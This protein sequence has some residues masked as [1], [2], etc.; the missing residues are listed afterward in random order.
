[1]N[2]VQ[3]TKRLVQKQDRRLKDIN[4]FCRWIIGNEASDRKGKSG[5]PKEKLQA[6][7]FSLSSAYDRSDIAKMLQDSGSVLSL[8][9][10]DVSGESVGAIWE[11]ESEPNVPFRRISS[12]LEIGRPSKDSEGYFQSPFRTLPI[13]FGG[14]GESISILK[15]LS[16]CDN[17]DQTR[18]KELLT[19]YYLRKV[20]KV[21]L[22]H[23]LFHQTD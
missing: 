8:K 2:Q 10:G 21:R 3:E 7:A 15:K 23:G 9:L 20:F 12:Q 14:F 19:D 22:F 4:V 6:T 18:S 16:T 11:P 5:L 13:S 1:M 17:F